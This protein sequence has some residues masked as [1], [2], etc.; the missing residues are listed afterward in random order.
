ML[1]CVRF[2]YLFVYGELGVSRGAVCD[3]RKERGDFFCEGSM[4]IIYIVAP[5]KGGLP[6]RDPQIL[7]SLILSVCLSRFSDKFTEWHLHRGQTQIL[8]GVL[9]G[10]SKEGPKSL[11]FNPPVELIS[12]TRNFHHFFDF[13]NKNIRM[14]WRA[15]EHH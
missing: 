13:L 3:W 14:L 12:G 8:L 15:P 5:L 6:S 9:E 11:S 10:A 1:I 4:L 2:P 7:K